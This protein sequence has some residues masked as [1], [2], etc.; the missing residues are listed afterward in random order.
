MLFRDRADAGKQLAARLDTLKGEPD[1]L[2]LGIPRGGVIVAA[3]IARALHAPLDILMA[4]KIGAP[5]NPEFAIGAVTS[6]GE[7]WLDE[8]AIAEDNINRAEVLRDAER[9]R[10]AMQQRL[11]KYRGER[12]AH[13]LRGKTVIVV[14]DGIATGSTMRVALRALRRE[15]PARL[16]LAIPVAPGEVIAQLGDE[17]D[18]VVVL[19]TPVPFWAVGRFY[20]HFE[21]TQD[22]DVI[23]I[24]RAAT[25]E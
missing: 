10:D 6:T 20:E 5:D 24:L 3:E 14:D 9:E 21:Q 4:H 18:E 2:V 17:C 19:A 12:A 11:K 13:D 22:R 25:Q 15:L 23:Q 7:T 16:V 1:L 8:G